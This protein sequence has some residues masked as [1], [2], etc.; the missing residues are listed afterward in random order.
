MQHS[1]LKLGWK[2]STPDGDSQ[3]HTKYEYRVLAER[4]VLIMFFDDEDDFWKEK[5]KKKK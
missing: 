3:N 4:G 1:L 5:K 2:S